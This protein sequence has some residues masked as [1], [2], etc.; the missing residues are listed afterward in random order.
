MWVFVHGALLAAAAACGSGETT[1]DATASCNE[2]RQ[3]Q[4]QCFTNASFDE[5]VACR[6]KC[7]RQCVQVQPETCP[8]TFTCR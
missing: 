3:R 5:C 4:A 8:I 1:E 2:Q 7:G 6:E